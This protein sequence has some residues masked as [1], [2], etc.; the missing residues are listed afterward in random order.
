MVRRGVFTMVDMLYSLICFICLNILIFI[1]FQTLRSK[2]QGQRKKVF[3]ALLVYSIIY[4]S[5]DMI[6]GIVF[7]WFPSNNVVTYIITFVNYIVTNGLCFVSFQ[8]VC[9]Y[10]SRYLKKYKI[11]TKIS[12]IPILIATLVYIIIS[13]SKI[14]SGSFLDVTVDSLYI[15][16]IFFIGA[17]YYLGTF[18]IAVYSFL[19]SKNQPR[20]LS[21][22]I[23]SFSLIPILTGILQYIAFYDPYVSIGSMLSCFL[24]FCFEI[25]ADRE[26][27]MAEMIKEQQT[28]VLELCGE[29]LYKNSSSE[30]NISNLIDLVAKYYAADGVV[31]FEIAEEI[32]QIYKIYQWN[33]NLSD[34]VEKNTK[35]LSEK[36][37]KEWADVLKNDDA[38]YINDLSKLEKGN[39]S[40][41]KLLHELEIK[42]IMAVPI[43]RD[44][45]LLGIIII[46]NPHEFQHDFT[47]VKTV[48]LFIY[49]EIQK[50]KFIEK[51]EEVTG[52]VI[53]A[54]SEEYE[55]VFHID[56]ETDE[57]IPY[58]YTD[59]MKE[60]YGDKYANHITYTPAYKL[61]IEEN[62]IEE[63]K[64]EMFEFG[65]SDV[66]RLMLKN[67]HSVTK[68][69]KSN[70]N[71]IPEFFEAKWIK[72]GRS[73]DYPKSIVLG[74]ANINEKEMQKK[75]EEAERQLYQ[76]RMDS[77]IEEREEV[78]RD[79]QIDKLTMCYNKNSGLEI[80]N[81]FLNAKASDE[82]YTLIFIDLDNFKTINDTFG[83]LEG[84]ELLS[85][86]GK[87]I[88]N[89]IRGGDIAIR[90]GGDE[91]VIVL[92]KVDN[93]NVA[94]S[95]ANSIATEISK[96]A[97]GKEYSAT[98]SI[99]G[100]ITTSS[101]LN[102]S[103][104]F[105]DECL[106]KIKKQGR[107]G[108]QIIMDKDLK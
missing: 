54:L 100:F 58:R 33:K 50:R 28:S 108:V 81:K 92:K 69:Y 3:I 94:K 61:Y 17:M 96:L 8:F 39:A 73:D 62:V 23:I 107:D 18:V 66:L 27:S 29:I 56:L 20:R 90:F 87:A 85:G 76:L 91:F 57:L 48:S 46:E 6:W 36:L 9:L 2:V 89:K 12:V 77:L 31:V 55:S 99:G 59:K 88:K 47:I 11:I 72:I 93:E 14:F 44:A 13:I 70:I 71:G 65:D 63:D 86:I 35:E 101:D 84:D 37:I 83:H 80:L 78:E 41:V 32:N 49:S 10:C 30:K 60:L 95:K 26:M 45:K 51:A 104:E 21:R 52:A 25:L 106:Y 7:C 24:I 42:N 67:R 105:A 15:N 19:K 38:V 5:V 1:L 74:F 53:D 97:Y 98:C 22:S 102:R 4:C 34:K 64:L 82:F 103:M 79:S 40:L 68:K 43:I 75:R 16:S